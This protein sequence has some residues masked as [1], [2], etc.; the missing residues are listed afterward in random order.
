LFWDCTDKVE[1]FTV[2]VE[3]CVSIGR[4][5]GGGVGNCLSRTEEPITFRG[6]SYGR[7]ISG[8]T[9]R[10]LRARRE[11]GM[12]NRPMPLRGLHLVG[13]QCAEKQQL[14][15]Y[16][17]SRI[18]LGAAAIALNFSQPH[19]PTAGSPGVEEKLLHVGPGPRS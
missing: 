15:F 10:G 17:F 4:A 2:L 7:W 5:F 13:P 16:T 1:P 14:Q 8:A 18:N 6:A 3:D 11:P 9:L 12:P 19:T